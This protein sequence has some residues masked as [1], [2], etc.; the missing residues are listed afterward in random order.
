MRHRVGKTAGGGRRGVGYGVAH[1][2]AGRTQHRIGPIG[3]AVVV[4]V[5][6]GHFDGGGSA[7]AIPHIIDILGIGIAERQRIRIVK[8]VGT[9]AEV[10]H[11]RIVGTGL[12]VPLIVEVLGGVRMRPGA[13]GEDLPDVI[14][15]IGAVRERELGLAEHGSRRAGGKLLL[16]VD[17]VKN[18]AVIGRQMRHRVLDPRHH[19][20]RHPRIVGGVPA[21]DGGLGGCGCCASD[22]VPPRADPSE[23]NA[24]TIAGVWRG[25]SHAERRL[26][27]MTGRVRRGDIVEA[28][29]VDEFGRELA[30]LVDVAALAFLHA[31]IDFGAVGGD[32]RGGHL[33][34]VVADN[35]IAGAG[36]IPNADFIE[37]ARIAEAVV[38]EIG[39][40]I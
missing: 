39:Q 17:A 33:S 16:P 23:R 7:L 4:V 31:I 28:V 6:A 8:R 11:V 5:R 29:V 3:H 36:A 38:V 21:V 24:R 1:T 26:G 30:N 14:V 15:R 22:I 37:V 9:F 25:G 35:L 18:C 19:A 27:D 13:R 2:Q 10:V 12:V 32:I 40:F 20:V 34:H